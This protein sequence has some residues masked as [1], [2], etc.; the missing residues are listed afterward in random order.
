MK[1]FYKKITEIVP[2]F[3]VTCNYFDCVDLY[4]YCKVPRYFTK[5]FQINL[6]NILRTFVKVILNL[7]D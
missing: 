1:L 2:Q 6:E 7:I 3:L 4:F 5:M